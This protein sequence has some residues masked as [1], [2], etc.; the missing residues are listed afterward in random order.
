M[1]LAS[2][3]RACCVRWMAYSREVRRGSSRR[4]LERRR[5][6]ACWLGL[7]LFALT[8]FAVV[9]AAPLT[10]GWVE[11]VWIAE[12][13][14]EISAK[15]DSGADHSSLHAEDIVLSE[16]SGVL[17]ARFLVRDSAGRGVVLDRPVTRQ[18]M[19]KRHGT[20]PQARPVVRL[21]LCVGTNRREVDVSLVDRSGFDFPLLLGRS[22]L[23]GLVLIDVDREYLNEPACARRTAND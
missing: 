23:R 20:P 17:R 9:H 12:A 16:R 7:S 1:A 5:P 19:I 8:C 22:F 4:R 3:S 2:W 18:A 10:A 13:A 6:T 21:T 15:L 14:I 11:R